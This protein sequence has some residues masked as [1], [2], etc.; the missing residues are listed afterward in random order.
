ML[1]S[2]LTRA[3][4]AGVPLAGGAAPDGAVQAAAMALEVL[5][6]ETE[7]KADKAERAVTAKAAAEAKA[8]AVAAAEEAAVIDDA[9]AADGPTGDAAAAGAAAWE[10]EAVLEGVVGPAAAAEAA[11]V[12]V[13]APLPVGRLLTLGSDTESLKREGQ[14]LEAKYARDRGNGW[15][16]N[17]A[18][19]KLR[20]YQE[21]LLCEAGHEPPEGP[22]I[23]EMEGRGEVEG[24]V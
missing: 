11:E 14:R 17:H 22:S 4:M 10:V 6:R 21:I 13:E 8:K 23:E 2:G 9:A 7:T 3:E 24:G 5:R 18:L 20:Q 12:G 16:Y 15:V 19:G 1:L